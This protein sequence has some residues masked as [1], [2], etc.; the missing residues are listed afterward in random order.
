MV[1]LGAIARLVHF[2]RVSGGDPREIHLNKA[3]LDEIREL[4]KA[5]GKTM[6]DTR[7]VLSRLRGEPAPS[8]GPP[9]VM[10]VAGLP[11]VENELI[12]DGCAAIRPL[13]AMNDPDWL[14][15]VAILPPTQ[16]ANAQ[17]SAGSTPWFTKAEP[18]PDNDKIGSA[19]LAGTE[20]NRPTPTDIMMLAMEQADTFEEI[21]ILKVTRGG[22]VYMTSTMPK[23]A[24]Q[25]YIYKA[26]QKLIE[27]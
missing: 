15:K 16:E 21:I 24:A 2:C 13:E 9:G 18:V 19:A 8:V 11:A 7:S 17:Q 6:P 25:G 27:G 3:T 4:I 26:F 10:L 20:R 22:D 12:S 23:L 1:N 5:H 14:H